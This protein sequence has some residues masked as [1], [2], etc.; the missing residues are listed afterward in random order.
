MPFRDPFIS[1][2]YLWAVPDRKGSKFVVSTAAPSLTATDQDRR[3][4][5]NPNNEFGQII[6]ATLLCR[7]ARRRC[8][9][10][11]IVGE[12]SI[13]ELVSGIYRSLLFLQERSSEADCWST[14]AGAVKA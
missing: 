13:T 10:R 9:W 5:E 7:I 2:T 11:N 8:D 4:L 12:R 3:K 6:L 1:I 14:R